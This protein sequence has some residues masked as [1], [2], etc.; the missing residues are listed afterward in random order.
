M[1]Q[2]SSPRYY[3]IILV[4]AG[5][6]QKLY[7]AYLEYTDLCINI[8]SNIPQAVRLLIEVE[9]FVQVKL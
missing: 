8:N 2:S 4:L 6:F 7:E 5:E 3:A 9:N 1:P